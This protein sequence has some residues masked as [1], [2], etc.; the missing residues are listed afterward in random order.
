MV[1][2][3]WARQIRLSYEKSGRTAEYNDPSRTG[4]E[5]SSSSSSSSST[6]TIISMLTGDTPNMSLASGGTAIGVGSIIL[7]T[8]TSTVRKTTSSSGGNNMTTAGQDLTLYQQV[9]TM[10]GGMLPGGVQPTAGG[11][12][13]TTRVLGATVGAA[14]VAGVGYAAYKYFTKDG[15][16]RKIKANGQPYKRPTMNYANPK[17]LSKAER[18]LKSYIKHARKHVSAMGFAIKRKGSDK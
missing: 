2:D 18:R 12:A 4:R 7:P 13:A 17:A 11:I 10:V 6:P 15:T 8:P 14:A 3:I 16:A 1:E 5:V 9:D